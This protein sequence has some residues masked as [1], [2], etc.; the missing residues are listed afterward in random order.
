MNQNYFCIIYRIG[1][2]TVDTACPILYFEFSK[3]KRQ[4][5]IPRQA[6]TIYLKFQS[7]LLHEYYIKDDQPIRG[8]RKFKQSH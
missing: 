2:N 3:D 7:A 5:N 8:S 4:L 1:V 6:L